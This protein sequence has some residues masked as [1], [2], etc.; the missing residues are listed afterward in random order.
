MSGLALLSPGTVFARDYRVARPLKEGGM[1]AVYVA[2][3]LSTSRPCALKV[4][5]PELVNHPEARKRFL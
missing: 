5:Q 2:E 3:Q 1:G 4:M